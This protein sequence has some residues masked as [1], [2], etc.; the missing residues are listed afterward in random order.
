MTPTPPVKNGRRSHLG[1]ST[2]KGKRSKLKRLEE[3]DHA[4][5]S[6]A[7]VSSIIVQHTKIHIPNF[8][9]E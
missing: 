2:V 7:Q 3:S 9:Y 1:R 6:A 5:E 4:Q 8:R